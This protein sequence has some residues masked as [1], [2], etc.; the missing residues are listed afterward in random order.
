M[1]KQ[2]SFCEFAS[3]DVAAFGEHMRVVH[4]W[5]RITDARPPGTMLGWGGAILAIAA[6]F[7]LV[8]NSEQSCLASQEHGYCGNN[9]LV[10]FLFVI[11][12]AAIGFAVGVV[13]SRRL[14]RPKAP[15]L[16]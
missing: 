1:A 16:T 10:F 14:K 15:N 6:L 4:Q 7:L 13:V 5:D 11:P 12:L 9:W 8:W 3:D 2:C